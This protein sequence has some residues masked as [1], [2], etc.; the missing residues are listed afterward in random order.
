MKKLLILA[1]SLYTLGG[2]A[3]EKS[4]EKK[5]TLMERLTKNP[6]SP[7][8][9]AE[10]ATKHLTLKLDLTKDQQSKV[11]ELL[12]AAYTEGKNK[13]DAKKSK[14]KE[15]TEAERH[16][17]QVERLDA[18]IALKEKMKGILN[19]EQYAKYSEM[20]DRK[21]KRRKQRRKRR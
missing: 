12:S 18:Q 16:N 11:Q 20:M 13:M 7:E 21:M 10:V 14:G 4:E 5:K 1:L 2:F 8:Q 9:R 3:Q 6:K 19:A 17:M 15:L